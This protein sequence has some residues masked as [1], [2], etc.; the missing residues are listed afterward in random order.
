MRIFA[1]G[2]SGI[3]LD[4]PVQRT[5]GFMVQIALLQWFSERAHQVFSEIPVRI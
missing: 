5:R 3:D 4:S 1:G 2:I